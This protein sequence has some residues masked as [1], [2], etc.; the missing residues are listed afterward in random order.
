ME[1]RFVAPD[2]RALDE[3]GADVLVLGHFAEE[4]PL[5]GLAGLIDFRL[6]GT[7]S[8]LL[9]RG[10]TGGR[11]TERVLLPARPR[12]K[13]D[14]VLLVGLGSRVGFDGARA[15]AALRDVFA[16]LDGLTA[17]SVIL[18]L[19]GRGDGTLSPEA[20]IEAFV[21]LLDE[22]HEQDDVTLVEPADVVRQMKPLIERARRRARAEGGA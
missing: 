16:A 17:R 11:A 3:L 12:L 14:R 18:C 10:R 20:A 19:P 7:L 6:A 2:L 9:V 8:R 13:Q 22:P 15:A 1:V 5:L 21:P 4:R